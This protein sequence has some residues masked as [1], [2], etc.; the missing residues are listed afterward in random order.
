MLSLRLNTREIMKWW[1]KK[2]KGWIVPFW[3]T[4]TPLFSKRVVDIGFYKVAEMVRA[5][6]KAE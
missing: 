3:F 5:Q 2:V 4:E 6:R 1:Q